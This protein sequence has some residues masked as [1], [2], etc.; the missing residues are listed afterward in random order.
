V[1]MEVLMWS[2][3]SR[4]DSWSCDF[5]NVCLV[6]AVGSARSGRGPISFSIYMESLCSGHC[7]KARRLVQNSQP[8][9]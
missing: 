2:S 7:T 4:D 8:S 3:R 6:A 5:A 1:S 9:G